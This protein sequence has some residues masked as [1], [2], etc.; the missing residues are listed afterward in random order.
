MALDKASLV[1][2]LAGAIVGGGLFSSSR[3]SADCSDTVYDSITV[4]HGEAG[5]DDFLECEV[6][7]GEEGAIRLR[8]LGENGVRNSRRFERREP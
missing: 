6:L 7:S 5:D 1:A 8:C 4:A 3:V 2:L